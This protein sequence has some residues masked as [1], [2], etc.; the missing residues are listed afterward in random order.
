MI[1]RLKKTHTFRKAYKRLKKSGRFSDVEKL[2][3]VVSILTN[4]IVLPF[5]YKDHQLTGRLLKYRE[6]HIKDDLLLIYSQ[7]KNQLILTLINIGSHSKLF[8]S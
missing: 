8:K 7:N 4:G 2:K 1:Y 3:H 6:C 5:H